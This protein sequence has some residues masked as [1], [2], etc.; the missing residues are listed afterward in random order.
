[1]PRFN[2]YHSTHFYRI[3]RK[4]IGNVRTVRICG[5]GF[6]Q[7]FIYYYPHFPSSFSRKFTKIQNPSSILFASAAY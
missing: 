3:V 2:S 7:E 4:S 6:L 5:M 1:M